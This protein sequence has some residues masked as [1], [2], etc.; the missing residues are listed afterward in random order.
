[1]GGLLTKVNWKHGFKTA[2]AAGLC[3]ALARIFRLHQGYWACVSAIVVMQSETAATVIASRER[4]VGTAIGALTGWLI[5]IY[6]HGHLLI[7][8][9][10]VLIC[11]WAPEA[12]GLKNAGRLAGVAATIILLVPASAAYWR[13]ALDRFL[14]VSLGILVALAVSQTIWRK[15]TPRK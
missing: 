7:Y 5:A 10:A 4:L 3:L 15:T 11:M 8:V 6:W 1:M 13:I 9:V 2:I 14:E 12:L